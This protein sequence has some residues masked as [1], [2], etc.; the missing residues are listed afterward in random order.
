MYK[1]RN[2]TFI[3]IGVFLLLLITSFLLFKH[4]IKPES[5]VSEK[6]VVTKEIQPEV[7]STA[8]TPIKKV[9]EYNSDEK[10]VNTVER[11]YK[12]IYNE[13]K[14]KEN[15]EYFYY[16]SDELIDRFFPSD[17][18]NLKQTVEVNDLTVYRNISDPLSE[19][20][21]IVAS[22]ELKLLTDNENIE[23]ERVYM[24]MTLEDNGKY[25]KV[26]GLEEFNYEKGVYYE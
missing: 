23:A 24:H 1:F 12:L 26:I 18:R 14:L 9:S 13:E 4:F 16:M 19:N 11:F 17:G 3:G 20:Y 6:E 15:E 5:Y 21:S 2:K 8:D 22:Y 7:V 10:L 25:L